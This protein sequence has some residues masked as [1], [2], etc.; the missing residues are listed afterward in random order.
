M[1]YD[2]LFQYVGL[3]G[4]GSNIITNYRR[5]KGGRKCYLDLEKHFLTDSHDKKKGIKVENFD[6]YTRSQVHKG[7]PETKGKPDTGIPY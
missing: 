3:T 6:P 5:K 7:N 1:I 4:T 2:I